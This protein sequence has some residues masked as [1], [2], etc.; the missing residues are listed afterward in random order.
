MLAMYKKRREKT[1]SDTL[2]FSYRRG[3]EGI[4]AVP[5]WVRFGVFFILALRGLSSPFST[6]RTG[7]RFGMADDRGGYH[8]GNA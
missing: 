4:G 5:V 6:S 7:N 8:T 1:Q 2:S 3:F